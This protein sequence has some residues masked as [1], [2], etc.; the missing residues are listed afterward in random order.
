MMS[1]LATLLKWLRWCLQL[2]LKTGPVPVHVAFIMDGNRRFAERQHMDTASGHA[3]GY[4]KVIG[5][6]QVQGSVQ[7]A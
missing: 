2:L 5:G 1:V 4:H 3:Q 7:T 6:D